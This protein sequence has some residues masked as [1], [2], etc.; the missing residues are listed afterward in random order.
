MRIGVDAC[1]WSNRRGFGRYTR[2]LLRHMVEESDRHEFVFVVDRRTADE[3]DFPSRS[4]LEVVSTKTQPTVAASVESARSVQDLWKMGR[5]ASRSNCDVFFFPA[6]YSYFPLQRKV[7]TIVTFHDAIAEN[8]PDLV[9]ADRRSR[10]FWNLKTRWA[11]RQAD[12]L[13]TVSESAKSQIVE[14]FN[15]PPSAVHVVPEAAGTQFR[16]VDN[17]STLLKIRQQYL[18]PVDEPVILYVGGISPHK[19]L[20]GLLRSLSLL[21]R[22]SSEPWHLVIVGDYL[23][24][25]FLGCYKQMVD[26]CGRLNLSERV[27]FTG[28]VPD[29]DLVLLY[30]TATMLVLP[31]FCEGFGLPV[32][33]AMACGL[34]VVASNRGSLPEVIGSSGICFD[35][36]DQQELT[37]A[38]SRLLQ[39]RSLRT[40]MTLSGLKRSA[41]FSWSAAARQTIRLIEEL[42][43]VESSAA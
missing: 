24:D 25:S 41:E 9:F 39:N 23:G 37:S 22:T 34:P 40:K 35:P 28:F 17:E 12:R 11:I 30:N 36:T 10:L 19:N 4:K 2:E 43:H 33:E 15:V 29:D 26:L 20:N 7:P 18:L 3:Y 21:E 38:I 5:A 27:T 42:G 31:S 1:C 8:H 16:P 6:V 14:S 32:I 13:L